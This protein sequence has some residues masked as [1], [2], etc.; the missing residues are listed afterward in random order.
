VVVLGSVVVV[1]VVGLSVVVVVVVV[2]ATVV[3][4]VVVL[5]DVE[6]DVDVLVEDDVVVVVG[7]AVVV[8]VVVGTKLQHSCASISCQLPSLGLNL[9]KIKLLGTIRPVPSKRTYAFNLLLL[10]AMIKEL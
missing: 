9:C 3:V 6:V 10:F 1:V 2:G 7:V 5:V 8:V 4:V